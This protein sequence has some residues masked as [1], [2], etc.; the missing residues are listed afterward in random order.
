MVLTMDWLGRRW[1]V[2]V[3]SRTFMILALFLLLFFPIGFGVYTI[4]GEYQAINN[5]SIE[6]IDIEL[7]NGSTSNRVYIRVRISNPTKY[8]TPRFTMDIFIRPITFSSD[9]FVAESKLSEIVVGSDSSTIQTFLVNLEHEIVEVTM[10]GVTMKTILHCKL[11]F[12]L[13][14]FSKAGMYYYQSEKN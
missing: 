13:I 11:L 1:N 8:N 10:K 12:N 5:I 3:S 2:I 4:I 14:Q 9:R 6:V 7:E